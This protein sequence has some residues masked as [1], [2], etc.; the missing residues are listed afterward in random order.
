MAMV[1]SARPASVSDVDLFQARAAL[2]HQQS[3]E[4][5]AP[6]EFISLIVEEL[7]YHRE[8]HSSI[9]EIEHECSHLRKELRKQ[10][11]INEAFQKELREI[12]ELITQV[13][14]GDLSQRARLHPLEISPDIATFKQT[15]NTMMDELQVFSQEVSKVAR[16]VGTEGILGGQANITG[17][18]GIWREL[19]ENVN[20][21]ASNL[22][23]QVRE[24]A[25]VTTAVAHG[26]LSQKIERQARGEIYQLQ[27]TINSMVDQLREFAQ[28]VTKISKDVGFYGQLGGQ[29]VVH[30]V[31][32]VWEDLT[33]NVNQ[34]AMRLTEQVREIADVTTAVARG[35]LTKKVTAD[36]NGEILDLK[37]TINAM[38]DR[39]NKFAFEVSRVAR[40]VG[41]DGTLGGQAQVENVEGLWVSYRISL[42]YSCA[43]VEQ[44]DLT[45][46]VNTMAQNLTSQVRSI[47]GVTQA[48]AK[49]DLS[50][51]I[52]VHAQGEIL[53]LKETINSMVDGLGQ[54]ATELKRVARGM[55]TSPLW[56][57]SIPITDHCAEYRCRC[58]GK[59]GR[60]SKCR[61]DAR[62]VARYHHRCEYHGGQPYKPS[63]RLWRDHRCGDQR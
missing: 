12:G 21:M 29:A 37:L 58:G 57:M 9:A 59:D 5:S 11:H 30:G 48:I 10:T 25:A 47:S 6:R 4:I 26:D 62:T 28:E 22:T 31:E 24:I 33:T 56:S 53:L 34:M 41:T 32:G 3:P 19:T 1:D 23:L 45:D 39:L 18:N 50:T 51:K 43:D 42:C 60:A 52:Q 35:D 44:R 14:H 15:I 61:G 63:A 27:K 38:V 16:E 46:N 49:G 2:Q 54:F 20:I 36:V 40:E 55:S 13:A 17:V 8:S 7:I